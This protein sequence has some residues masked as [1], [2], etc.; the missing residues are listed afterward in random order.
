M[1]TYT[2]ISTKTFKFRDLVLT[3]SYDS[4]DGYEMLVE[5]DRDE[6]AAE[7]PVGVTFPHTGDDVD[8]LL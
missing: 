7:V 5:I 3:V 1:T 6:Y 4:I 2:T 8:V